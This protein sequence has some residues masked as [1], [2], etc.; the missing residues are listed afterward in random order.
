[1]FNPT[2]NESN[3][4]RRAK[5][6]RRRSKQLLSNSSSLVTDNDTIIDS[7]Y[8]TANEDEEVIDN[9]NHHHAPN[10]E[11]Q[12]Q[13]RI[14][15][16]KREVSAAS[17]RFGGYAQS[18]ASFQVDIEQEQTFDDG[19]NMTAASSKK[20][21]PPLNVTTNNTSKTSK[22]SS[23]RYGQDVSSPVGKGAHASLYNFGGGNN[24]PNTSLQGGGAGIIDSTDDDDNSQK[25][26]SAKSAKKVVKIDVAVQTDKEP[27][28]SNVTNP[29]EDTILSFKAKPPPLRKYEI[30]G[31]DPDLFLAMDEWVEEVSKKR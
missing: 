12:S 22:S 31:D 18:D 11:L 7:D 4:R 3:S 13:S 25:S 17:S 28:K 9:E 5:A 23:P 19:E 2:S 26:N 10:S 8:D 29:L 14:E 20:E 27:P 30:I 6:T 16:L 21:L 15:Q 1:M 24:N